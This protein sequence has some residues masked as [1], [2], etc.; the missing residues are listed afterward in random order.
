MMIIL[1]RQ[2]VFFFFM[3][4]KQVSL[5]GSFVML[6]VVLIVCLYKS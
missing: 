2:E 1:L 4:E 6:Y 3:R 5:S